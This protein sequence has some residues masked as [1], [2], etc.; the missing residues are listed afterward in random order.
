MARYRTIEA[1]TSD[2]GY[3]RLTEPGYIRHACGITDTGCS[4]WLPIMYEPDSNWYNMYGNNDDRELIIEIAN[5]NQARRDWDASFLPGAQAER[6]AGFLQNDRTH[7]IVRFN[8]DR[9]GHYEYE[10]IGEYCAILFHRDEYTSIHA[11]FG[12]SFVNGEA[13]CSGNGRIS[14]MSGFASS[15]AELVKRFEALARATIQT[16]RGLR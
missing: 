10:Y 11:Q 8:K 7:V 2:M 15:E 13:L 9:N 6:G 3:G 14:W 1:A 16:L 12:S 5:K 4:V